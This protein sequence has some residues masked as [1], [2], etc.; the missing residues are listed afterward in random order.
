MLAVVCRYGLQAGAL[1]LISALSTTAGNLLHSSAGILSDL[2]G[3]QDICTDIAAATNERGENLCQES[4]EATAAA[5][6]RVKHERE[7]KN[8][9]VSNQA[10]DQKRLR[11][12]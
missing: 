12:H 9:T 4:N 10:I 7:E 11:V 2:R 5:R 1:V 6:V 8:T 3:E